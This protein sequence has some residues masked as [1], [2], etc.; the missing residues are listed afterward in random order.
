VLRYG[1]GVPSNSL[2]TD[3]DVYRNAANGDEYQKV[4]GAYVLRQNLKGQ[5]GYTPRKGVDYVDGTDG[6][7]GNEIVDK[8]YA[9]TAADNAGYKEGDQWFYTI[10]LSSYER[11]A[12]LNG[13]W[14]LRFRK[15]DTV[16][17]PVSADTQAPNLS[18]TAPASGATVPVNTQLTLTA[19]ATD[20]VAVTAVEFL[21]GATGA[22]LGQGAK[23]GNTYT[24]PYTV[25]TAGPLSLVAKASDAAGNSQTATVNIT[26]Q[27]P[28]SNVLPTANAGADVTLQLP[29]NQL[30]LMGTGADADGTVTAYAWSQITG[31]NTATGMPATSQNVVVSNLTAGIYQFRLTVT[32]DKQGQKSDD[33]LVTVNAATSTQDQYPLPVTA[34]GEMAWIGFDSTSQNLTQYR[35]PL[36]GPWTRISNPIVYNGAVSGKSMRDAAV[37]DR[38]IGGYYYMAISQVEYNSFDLNSPTVAW[39]RSTDTITW[40]HIASI[41]VSPDGRSAVSCWSPQPVTNVAT[42][43]ATAPQRIT[44]SLIP[45]NSI[46]F[47][48]FK[49]AGKKWQLW[50]K[51]QDYDANNPSEFLGYAESDTPFSGFD[52]GPGN[53]PQLG[54]HIEGQDLRVVNGQVTLYYDGENVGAGVG[55]RRRISTDGTTVNWGAEL[56]MSADVA[57]PARH[58]SPIYNPPAL[59]SAPTGPAQGPLAGVAI[60]SSGQT[61]TTDAINVSFLL[62]KAASVDTTIQVEFFDSSHVGGNAFTPGNSDGIQ[63]YTIPAGSTSLTP[64]T[65]I[66][67]PKRATFYEIGWKILSVSNAAVAI[68]PVKGQGTYTIQPANGSTTLPVLS[69]YGEKVGSSGGLTS[70]R[71]TLRVDT[72]FAQPTTVYTQASTDGVTNLY[73]EDNSGGSPSLTFPAGQTKYVLSPVSTYAQ[74]AYAYDL[75]AKLRATDKYFIN[76]NAGTVQLIIDAV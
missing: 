8:T 45:P 42:G 47:V 17:P 22:S 74:K 14:R 39:L 13:Q 21:N 20:N 58:G 49:Q 52:S 10:S 26:V 53:L 18:F 35:G 56:F 69:I 64:I 50:W 66:T 75:I 41:P 46:D 51:T 2:G 60:F 25:S 4:A 48:L 7:D 29:S 63:S 59:P 68:D 76:A 30:A 24:L 36:N 37:L 32:D 65:N 44:G 28:V 11:Y 40:Q 9:P 62:S 72:P 5:P 34:S 15:A 27:A 6:I 1:T 73:P 57:N 16:T 61:A 3:G 23:N 71:Y 70:V 38:L 43:A 54:Y 12:H 33:V 67:K 19:T 55:I 31:P